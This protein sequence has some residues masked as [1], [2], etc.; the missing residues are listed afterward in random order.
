MRPS[1]IL[2]YNMQSV[3]AL[4]DLE[5]LIAQKH[6][7]FDVTRILPSM[8]PLDEQTNRVWR[9]NTLKNFVSEKVGGLAVFELARRH[10]TATVR[11]CAL[12][13]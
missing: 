8:Q 5:R 1:A 2:P 4:A 9:R 13:T 10:S 6:P 3:I 7:L 12:L 11:F